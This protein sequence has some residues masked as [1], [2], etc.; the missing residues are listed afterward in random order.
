MRKW[1]LTGFVLLLLF[2]FGVNFIDSDLQPHNTR[3]TASFSDPGPHGVGYFPN[4][5]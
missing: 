4:L 3:H 1:L 5:G 2:S